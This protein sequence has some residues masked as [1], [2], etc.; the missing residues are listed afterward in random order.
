MICKRID[1]R[2][3]N[4]IWECKLEALTGKVGVQIIDSDL[5]REKLG[6][7]GLI[8]TDATHM[9]G[10]TGKMRRSEFLPIAVQSG[11]DMILYYRDHDEDL[12]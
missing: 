3:R 9:V 10:L 6:F 4:C 1:I 12:R 2:I 8:I 7:N 5:L 11:C